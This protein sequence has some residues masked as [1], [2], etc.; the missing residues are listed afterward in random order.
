VAA[1]RAKEATEARAVTEARAAVTEPASPTPSRRGAS[2]TRRPSALPTVAAAL[3]LFFVAFEFLAFQLRTGNDPSL[4]S[5][6]GPRPQ[7]VRKVVRRKVVT[8]VVP[9]GS[10]K[11]GAT[12]VSGPATVSSTPAPAPAPAPVVTSTS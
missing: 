6:Q 1:A 10:G 2:A 8:D 9:G 12:T 4:A 7:V 3:A 11:G 5:A